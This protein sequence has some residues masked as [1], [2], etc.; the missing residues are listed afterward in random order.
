MLGPLRRVV[1]NFIRRS[2]VLKFGITLLVIGLVVGGIGILGTD[3]I[4][5]EASDRVKDD[6]TSEAVQKA[7]GFESWHDRNELVLN[8][9]ANRVRFTTDREVGDLLSD[10]LDSIAPDGERALLVELEDRV[11]ADSTGTFANTSLDS[12]PSEFV[13]EEV[14][15]GSV[16]GTTILG[17]T[18]AD[19][20]RVLAYASPVRGTDRALVYFA[21]LEGYARKLVEDGDAPAYVFDANAD[22]GSNTIIYDSTGN[23]FGSSYGSENVV[24]AVGSLKDGTASDA[25][26]QTISAGDAGRFPPLETSLPNTSGQYVPSYANVEGTPYG[27]VVHTPNSEAFGFVNTIRQS[28]FIAAIVAVLGVGIIGALLGRSTATSI[29]RL[30]R[31]SEEMER[32][33]L[34]VDFESSRVDNIGQ[35]YDGMANMRNALRNQI[36]EAREARQ[37]A[38]QARE[39]AEETSQH[40]QAKANEYRDAMQAVA[41]G[42]LSRRLTP[43]ERNEAMEEIATEFNSMMDEI[44]TTVAQLKQ[45]ANEVAASSQQVTASAEEVRAASKNVTESIQQISDGAD[46]QDE[47]LQSVSGEMSGLSTTVEEIASLSNEVADISEQTAET[48][49]RG[50]EA[51]QEAIEGMNQI[52]SESQQAV[53]QIERLDEEMAQIDELIDF[54]TDVANQTNRL[55]LNANI[56]A[57]RASSGDG[58]GGFG[59]VA[60][61]IKELAAETKDATENMEESIE[62]VQTQ[63]DAAVDSVTT[64]G[65]LIEENVEPIRSAVEALDEIAEYAEE[66][67]TGVQE[68]SAATEQQAASTQEVVAMVDEAAS[69][70]ENTSLASE[71]VAAA[72][73]QQTSAMTEVSNSASELSG[74]ASRLSE[75][76]DRFTTS[77][78]DGNLEG[79]ELTAAVDDGGEGEADA[80]DAEFE[81]GFDDDLGESEFGDGFEDVDLEPAGETDVTESGDGEETGDDGSDDGGG[82]GGNDPATFGD[83]DDGN[84]TED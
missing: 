75:K 9:L 52:E 70:A 32:G 35:L 5:K 16:S 25:P 62:R 21:N 83:A 26:Y 76:L 7:D 78:A 12:L 23:E 63:A 49:R 15:S 79:A 14:S 36:V 17:A 51:A 38:E 10:Q 37:E 59:A 18:N 11:V 50:S 82:L 45:F 53:E 28:G 13:F 22:L 65:D 60:N 4:S 58:D 43:S 77:D 55:A 67:N 81:D 31:K 61:E 40:L 29:D 64:T 73:E 34:E 74:Q 20:E 33:N 27:V 8:T 48:G 57:S 42:D 41:A 47:T 54:V 80:F 19:G 44:E 71:N 66:T 56:E 24:D 39:R 2:Y 72:A 69:I 68:I 84:E 1:P 6:L 30:R 3:Y 46:K